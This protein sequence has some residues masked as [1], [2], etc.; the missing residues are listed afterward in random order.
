MSDFE[1]EYF[2]QVRC[3]FIMYLKAGRKSNINVF[4]VDNILHVI[5]INLIFNDTL[6][7]EFNHL[8]N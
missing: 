7:Y 1:C 8:N 3:T 6:N 2:S 5:V 4:K